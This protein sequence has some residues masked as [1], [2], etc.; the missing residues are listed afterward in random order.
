M[1]SKRASKKTTAKRKGGMPAFVPT[2]IQRTMVLQCTGLGMTPK[3]LRSL[4]ICPRTGKPVGRVVFDRVFEHELESGFA[5]MKSAVGMS[6]AQK[7]MSPDHPGSVTSAI[8]LEKSRFGMSDKA[9]DD[10]TNARNNMADAWRAMVD[11]VPRSPEHGEE[12]DASYRTLSAT[13]VEA[14]RKGEG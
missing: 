13:T 7:A 11:S 9:S 14:K 12:A 6:L 5:H 4:V 10:E 8:W 3:E 1:A 2:D